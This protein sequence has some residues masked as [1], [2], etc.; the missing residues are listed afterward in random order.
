MRNGIGTNSKGG[1]MVALNND[2]GANWNGG[3]EFRL[4][5]ETDKV[6]TELTLGFHNKPKNDDGP[7]WKTQFLW[8]YK[9]QGNASWENTATEVDFGTSSTTTPNQMTM[10]EAFVQADNLFGKGYTFWIGKRFYRDV[11]SNINDLFYFADASGNGA[12][13][14]NIQTN[15][16][17]FAFAMIH[18]VDGNTN[19]NIGKP[20]MTFLDFRLFDVPVTDKVKLNFWVGHGMAP[21]SIDNSG[22]TSYESSQ[23]NL[24]AV[25]MRS[26]LSSGFNDFTIMWGEK[27][28]HGLN[29]YG[30]AT[31]VA[32]DAQNKKNRF[33]IVNDLT[34]KV[35][36][37]IETH[38]AFIYEQRD[39]GSASNSKEKW[40]SVG[41]RPTWMISDHFNIALEVGHSIVEIESEGLGKR[42]LTRITLAP[43][44]TPDMGI[45]SRPVL[46]AFI[47]YTKWNDAN[48]S[49]MPTPYTGKS[50]GINAGFQTEVW[51]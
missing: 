16:G 45:W 28:L 31:T 32:G 3:N 21:A 27:L 49:K 41:A 26:D 35:T 39:N 11:N 25:R 7:K 15:F 8:A 36:D 9:V 4:G 12:G 33:R 5:N 34:T 46:R 14:E 30:D 18:Q 2:G 6:Y 38:L 24:A 42:H 29:L 47:S 37:N 10:R 40:L 19:T 51:F 13:I 44:L 1:D 48:K 43:Q 23:G 20:K 17:K 50:E 22:G